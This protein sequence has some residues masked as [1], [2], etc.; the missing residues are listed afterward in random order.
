M[1]MSYWPSLSSATSLHPTLLC[2]HHP[3]PTGDLTYHASNPQM[4]MPS[5]PLLSSNT[6]LSHL[7]CGRLP[8]S[9]RLQYLT[10]GF[11]PVGKGPTLYPALAMTYH[12]VSPSTWRITS[13][14]SAFNSS[15]Q[16]AHLH[17]CLPHWLG[18]GYPCVDSYLLPF[19]L[20]PHPYPPYTNIHTCSAPSN[21]FC[22]NCSGRRK[23]GEKRKR[24][25]NWLWRR[26]ILVLHH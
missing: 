8:Q 7:S 26:R 9:F 16:A 5:L 12:T 2:G 22:T 17:K 3:H 20:P 21:D 24:G 4:W 10:F 13:L 6:M 19:W 1:W 25:H 18:P 11:T 23:E 14:C 15:H